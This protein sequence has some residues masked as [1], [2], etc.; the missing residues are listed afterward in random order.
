MKAVIWLDETLGAKF[1]IV[2]IPKTWSKRQSYREQMI[3]AVSE[4]DDVLFGKLSRA[5][6]CRSMRSRRE[7]AKPHRAES[8]PG[9]LRFRVQEQSARPCSM[10]WS[11]T[12]FAAR[13]SRR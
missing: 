2:D 8:F 13:Y 9:D 3:E 6:R 10:R 5:S 4:F 1:D 12:C 7:S 11:I